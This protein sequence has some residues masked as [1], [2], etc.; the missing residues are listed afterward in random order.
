MCATTVRLFVQMVESKSPVNPLPAVYYLTQY[1]DG[2]MRLMNG[3]QQDV[4]ELWMILH[5]ILND[6]ANAYSEVS[7][8]P[9]SCD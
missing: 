7:F 3:M 1:S 8:L 9:Y 2:V 6:P 4:H 5:E